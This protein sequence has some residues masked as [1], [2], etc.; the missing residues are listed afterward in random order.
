MNLEIYRTLWG[1]TTP[2]DEIAP[3]LKEVGFTGVEGRIPLTEKDLTQ[4]KN[5]LS[6][7]DL[8]YIAILFSGGDVIPDQSETPKHHLDRMEVLIESAQKLDAKFI[9]VLAGNDRWGMSE[10][11]DFFGKAQEL[12]EKAGIVCSFE[13]HRGTSLY[14]PWITLDL[15]KQLPN[16]KFTMDISHWILVCERLLDK[17]EDDLSEYLD[18]V[19]HVQARVGYD[20]GAQV[21]HP[22]APEFQPYLAFHQ[23]VWESI[24]KRHLAEGRNVTT[25]TTEFG[26]DGYLHHL[27]FTNVP[28]ADLWSL[29][30]WIAIEER[31]HFTRFA[32]AHL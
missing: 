26:P 18:R 27:P 32:K 10:Q 11:V 3:K 12:S 22:G 13:T 1:V 14:S 6:Q 2:L 7:N 24:W 15:I 30:D 17:P 31:A 4:F 9:N 21:P 5:G 8:D 25:M 29:N 16:L 23:S 19:Y 20:Q 28:V